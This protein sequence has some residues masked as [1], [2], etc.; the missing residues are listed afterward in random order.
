[1]KTLL[2]STNPAFTR[3]LVNSAVVGGLFRDLAQMRRISSQFPRPPQ[4][5]VMA[6]PVVP[7]AISNPSR[8]ANTPDYLL[9][10]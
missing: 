8:A 10:A 7:N 2:N 6:L 3:S 5:N 4:S 9:V 1:M